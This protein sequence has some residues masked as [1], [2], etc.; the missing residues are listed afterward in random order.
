V[1]A[2][3]LAQV[4]VIEVGGGPRLSARGRRALVAVI[5]VLCVGGVV[6]W[7]VDAGSRDHDE[8]AVAA[9]RDAALRAD[10]RASSLVGFMVRELDPVLWKVPEGPR[11]DG[12]VALVAEAAARAL[13]GV[14]K[15]LAFCRR[16]GVAWLH[17][18]LVHRRDRYV[19][20]LDA[21]VR[22]L[23]DVAANGHSYYRDQPRLAALRDEA[24][25]P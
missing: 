5:A 7:R 8:R 10:L 17:R 19:N 1:Q 23:E 4:E 25:G 20:Y 9:C 21:R 18:D 6:A 14:R 24:F 2:E 13:P 11:R 22:R 3:D 16:T 15:A 12:L